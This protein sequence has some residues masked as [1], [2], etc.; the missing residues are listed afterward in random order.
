MWRP[1]DWKNPHNP[2]ANIFPDEVSWTCVRREHNAFEAGADAMLE[3]LKKLGKHTDG[4]APT[5]SIDVLLGQSGYLIL[6]P[7]KK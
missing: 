6:I 3:G 1:N 5:L 2:E 4:T 7:D